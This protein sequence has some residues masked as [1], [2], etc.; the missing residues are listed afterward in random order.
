ML[1]GA[2][3]SPTSLKDQLQAELQLSHIDARP[4]AADGAKA[5]GA[6]NRHPRLIRRV[7][8]ERCI[9]VPEV[10]MVCEVETFEPKL[11]VAALTEAEVLQCREVPGPD[12]GPRE[13]V[14]A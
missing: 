10:R 6:R 2:K 11:Q 13:H 7:A 12:A 4:K 1:A 3:P 5:S 9:G 8:G 14:A